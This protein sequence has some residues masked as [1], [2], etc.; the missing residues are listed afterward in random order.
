MR[1]GPCPAM[2]RAMGDVVNLRQARKARKRM[3]DARRAEANRRKHGATRAEKQIA[4][5]EAERLKAAL[6]GA[7]REPVAGA[8]RE[9]VA[10]ARREP[11]DD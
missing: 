7:Q 10:G 5:K 1:D 8:Q 2:V 6:D 11:L 4:A 3:D 9:P